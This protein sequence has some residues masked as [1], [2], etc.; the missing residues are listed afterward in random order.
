MFPLD[1][2]QYYFFLVG[3]ILIRE[4]FLL[5]HLGWKSIEWVVSIRTKAASRAY[6]R[7]QKYEIRR[8]SCWQILPSSAARQQ[9]TLYWQGAALEGNMQINVL[10]VGISC[11][12][13]GE[14]GCCWLFITKLF[15][16]L[17]SGLTVVLGCVSKNLA[18][19]CTGAAI[20]AREY[21]NL[22]PGFYQLSNKRTALFLCVF[23]ISSRTIH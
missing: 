8:T 14:N 15:G 5:R 4:F 22:F 3:G 20:R 1:F 21:S 10:R 7:H 17:C 9:C 23:C 19:I 13:S 16:E 11:A 12:P 2:H 18:F 6:D